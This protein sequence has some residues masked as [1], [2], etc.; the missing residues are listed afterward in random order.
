MSRDLS[1]GD[2]PT[3][4][5]T[6]LADG[7]CHGYAIAR[8]IERKSGQLFQMREGALYPALRVLEQDGFVE[9]QWEV[10]PSGPARKVYLITEEGR[11]ELVTRKKDWKTYVETFKRFLEGDKNAQPT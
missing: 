7:K 6:V 10:Q 2:T 5:L 9:G 11:R 1:R 8:E 4:I 3:L